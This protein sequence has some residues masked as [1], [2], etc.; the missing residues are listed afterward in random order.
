[1]TCRG[2]G[3]NGVAITGSSKRRQRARHSRS[4][5][6]SAQTA[7]N[8]EATQV[9][10]DQ[11]FSFSIPIKFGVTPVP[12]LGME[13]VIFVGLALMIAGVVFQGRRAKA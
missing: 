3:Y 10:V 7:A 6:S 11:P 13:A 12:G 8:L 9:G 2:R 5:I 4:A 1:M